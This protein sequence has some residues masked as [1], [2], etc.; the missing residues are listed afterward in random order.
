M[1]CVRDAS[2]RYL[3]GNLNLFS[4]RL[5]MFYTPS[6]GLAY[7]YPVR[8][9]AEALA[10]E[11]SGVVTVYAPDVMGATPTRRGETMELFG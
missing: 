1:Y 6:S 3:T 5:D 10:K 4:G 11:H 8:E 7:C 9:D 2:G